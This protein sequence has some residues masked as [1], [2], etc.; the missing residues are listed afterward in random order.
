MHRI[1]WSVKKARGKLRYYANFRSYA[2]KEGEEVDENL[3]GRNV[4]I[5]VTLPNPAELMA[6]ARM[7]GCKVSE[8]KKWISTDDEN[9]F[10]RLIVYAVV[11]RTLNKPA[12]IDL[13]KRLVIDRGF[14]TD[15][16][17]WANTFMNRYRSEG[18]RKGVGTRC[19]YRPAKAFKL[20]YNLAEE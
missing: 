11:R 8:E 2:N 13:L 4:D 19:L 18:I 16:W 3:K 1:T 12:K 7:L 20:I 10:F 5:R 6:I 14:D 17:W 15:A 9:V